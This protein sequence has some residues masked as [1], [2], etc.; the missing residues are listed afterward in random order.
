MT[1]A[2]FAV[3]DIET[4]GLDRKYDEIL[5]FGIVLVDENLDVIDTYSTLNVT[6]E[7]VTRLK[8]LKSSHLFVER[9]PDLAGPKDK[10]A[11]FV[12]EMHKRSGLYDEIM[13]NHANVLDNGVWGP[14]AKV[15]VNNFL[16]SHVERLGPHVKM[17][18]STIGF[19]K[20]FLE[21]DW[22]WNNGVIGKF[23]HYR[24]VD[25]SSLK[26]L[27]EMYRPEVI[28][29]RDESLK[30]KK[31]HRVIDDCLDTLSEFEVYFREMIKS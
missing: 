15:K 1:N 17:L 11:A 5:E 19:D 22:D 25:V 12:Y 26:T 13:L 3:I 4:T 14:P 6:Y 16:E 9:H 18:G 29:V 30:P 27:A 8:Q 28:K 7:T 2:T 31:S 24:V 23:F 20:A 21:D 10:Q